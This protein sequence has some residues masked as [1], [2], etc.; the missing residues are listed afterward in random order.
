MKQTVKNHYTID[1]SQ[2]ENKF[3]I[4][5][6]M[7]F[8]LATRNN[9][10]RRFLFVSKVLGKHMAVKANQS[11]AISR[12]LAMHYYENLTSKVAY[13]HKE[14]A[15]A[16]KDSSSTYMRKDLKNYEIDEQSIVIGFAE[17]AT[18][19]A[20]GVFDSFENTLAFYHTT[21]EQVEFSGN[22]ILFE[23]EH[24]HATSHKVYENAHM[25]L[26]S[27]KKIILVDDE[28][29][30]GNTLINI[31]KSINDQ[32]GIKSFSVLTLLDWR[33][34]ES[35]RKFSEF[36]KEFDI[37]VDV[38]SLI[39]GEILDITH[40]DLDLN[41]L[42]K[43]DLFIGETEKMLD[44][45]EFTQDKANNFEKSIYID[46]ISDKNKEFIK[47]GDQDKVCAYNG[48]TGRFGLNM[49]D[50]N[51]FKSRL[52]DISSK[53]QDYVKG[54]TLI[55]GTE[56]FMYLPLKIASYIGGDI[57]YKSTTRSP[58]YPCDDSNYPIKSGISFESFY[59]KDVNNYVYNIVEE[60]YDTILVFVEK[61]NSHVS[62][63][64]LYRKLEKICKN[65]RIVYFTD[66]KEKKNSYPPIIG[67]YSEDD[68]VFL[69]K[70]VSSQV[71]EQDNFSREKAIQSGV[72]YSE[73][74]PIEYKP[75]DEYLDI[76]HKSLKSFSKKLALAVA[77]TA[78]KIIKARGE[79]VVLVS[80]ARAGSPAGV[81]FKRYLKSVHKINVAHYSISI[82][83]GRG[84]D[85]NAIKFVVN[86]HPN[87]NIQ[88]VDGWTGKGAI[89]KELKEAIDKFKVDYG[90]PGTLNYELAVIAD[91]GHCVEIYG[92]REDFLI[93]NACL[94]S[95]VS[96]L[97][98]RTVFRDDIVSGEDYHGVKYYR[99]LESEDLS[100]YYIE[101]V[102]TY[103]DD[104]SSEAIALSRDFNIENE[105]PKWLGLEDVS[106]IE[107]DFNIESVHFIKPGIGE[108]TRV[109][110]RRIPWKILVREDSE[111]LEHVLKLA[112]EK[113]IPVEAYPLKAYH[114]CG[115]VKEL[116]GE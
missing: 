12:L 36:A 22:T 51:V 33:S 18:G 11:L 39:K 90:D 45:L 63:L 101:E 38:C 54:K 81:L 70:E 40:G 108:T 104:V 77:I 5:E 13:D 116:K 7:L 10:K 42:A 96:G 48:Y 85:E 9:S 8:E 97:L 34:L 47:Y 78:E 3:D 24:S 74:L 15:N 110:L 68:V 4:D 99:E 92:T 93:P 29:S 106:N 49:S 6:N 98:S 73:M 114:C 60:E 55:L 2:N 75:T 71:K 31:M 17:T 80:L 100:N 53:L 35:Q 91:P 88:F 105:D 83:R 20:H 72:H 28:I 109:L 41:D 94:N 61:I 107:R 59:N 30:T 79:D 52:D 58:I 46:L 25:K 87:Q 32:F 112:K 14:V 113:N 56:E 69:L 102:E 67:S 21:R 86:N 26:E 111:N 44:K 1:L 19:L 66:N 76:F 95:T 115:V 82:I 43:H 62:A 23:E 65:V 89:T 84:I 16:A 27:A 50:H 57:S 64:N 103:F 37:K